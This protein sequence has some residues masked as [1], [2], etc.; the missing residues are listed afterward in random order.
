MII[1]VIRVLSKQQQNI[2]LVQTNVSHYIMIVVFVFEGKSSVLFLLGQLPLNPPPPG[3]RS[4]QQKHHG[5]IT[6]YVCLVLWTCNGLC[7][8]LG[9]SLL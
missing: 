3:Q 9:V 1:V 4:I 7:I 6:D 8:L 2:C 5:K